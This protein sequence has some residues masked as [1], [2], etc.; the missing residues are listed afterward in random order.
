[1]KKLLALIILLA[2]LLSLSAC[3]GFG[4]I[5]NLTDLAEGLS[6]ISDDWEKHAEARQKLT[7]FTITIEKT[8][9]SGN[10]TTYTEMRCEQ[11][12]VSI[13]EDGITLV[14]F[15]KNTM[16]VLSPENK[17]GYSY[18]SEDYADTYRSI[19]A[20]PI[21]SLELMIFDYMRLFAQKGGSDKIAGFNTTCYTCSIEGNTLQ[22]WIEDEYG[23]TLK[24]RSISKEG[25]EAMEVTNFKIGG[26]SWSDITN[27]V[28]FDEYKDNIVDYSNLG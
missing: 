27:L 22:Y 16:Y 14:D 6:N 23:L 11:G 5:K 17:S 12:Y 3:S 8:N 28:K 15:N 1:M 20:S 9:E 2:I 25:G 24:Y 10:K 19:G 13:F 26:V 21:V 7:N 4:P 18:S